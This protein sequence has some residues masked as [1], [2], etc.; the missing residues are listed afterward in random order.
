MVPIHFT[1]MP[2]AFAGDPR[3][4]DLRF[5]CNRSDGSDIGQLV[6]VPLY[7]PAGLA[8]DT[9]IPLSRADVDGAAVEA[10]LDGWAGWALTGTAPAVNLDLLI[11]RLAAY[12]LA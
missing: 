8:A 7:P 6:A 2:C 12:G 4:F 3:R 9:V 5:R 11:A 1:A 10:A